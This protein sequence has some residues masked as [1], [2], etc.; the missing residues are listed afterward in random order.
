M[1]HTL[2]SSIIP[3]TFIL[4][5]STIDNYSTH[6]DH[7]RSIIKHSPFDTNTPALTFSTARSNPGPWNDH[8][9]PN[10][11][12]NILRG[13]TETQVGDVFWSDTIVTRI[14]HRHRLPSLNSSTYIRH[15][16]ALLRDTWP[17]R[18]QGWSDHQSNPS[19]SAWPRSGRREQLGFHLLCEFRRSI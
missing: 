10:A 15:V 14:V 9:P 2:A 12:S 6:S 4:Y 3:N 17:H 5:T 7:I 13:F 18:S 19:F 11:S 8:Y 16:C 1:N